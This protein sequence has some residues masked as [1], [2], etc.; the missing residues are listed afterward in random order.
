[1]VSYYRKM[2]SNN[3]RAVDRHVLQRKVYGLLTLSRC[4]GKKGFSLGVQRTVEMP[5]W[6][7]NEKRSLWI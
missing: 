6:C 1:M 7:G 4:L 2:V 3:D 5:P